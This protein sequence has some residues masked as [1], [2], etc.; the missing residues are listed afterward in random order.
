MIRFP[1]FSVQPY[2]F[3]GRSIEGGMLDM[4]WEVW[5]PLNGCRV[6]RTLKV[7]AAYRHELSGSWFSLEDSSTYG[8]VTQRILVE[9]Q[10]VLRHLPNQGW[11][12]VHS[13]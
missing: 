10:T 4:E 5:G 12:L 8:R 1:G 9:E 13:K 11:Q 3:G 6:V 7:I 2:S